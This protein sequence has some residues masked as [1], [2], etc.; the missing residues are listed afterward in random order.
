MEIIDKSEYIGDGLVSIVY[1]KYKH[2][3]YIRLSYIEGIV[4]ITEK[5]LFHTF[6]FYDKPDIKIYHYY[7]ALS[8]KYQVKNFNILEE[9]YQRI[10]KLERILK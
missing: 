8:E 10:M 1:V 7:D 9:I 6:C 2:V 5:N 4:W 3:K